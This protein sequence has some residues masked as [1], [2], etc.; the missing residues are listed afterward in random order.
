VRGVCPPATGTG[1]RAGACRPTSSACRIPTRGA[2]QHHCGQRPDPSLGSPACTRLLVGSLY[3]CACTM[4]CM[5]ASRG[6][7]SLDGASR[8]SLVLLPPSNNLGPPLDATGVPL[9]VCLSP[10]LLSPRGLSLEGVVPWGRGLWRLKGRVLLVRASRPGSGG[11]PGKC[12]DP[13][14]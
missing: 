3:A 6:C 7:G 10:D 13:K 8:T 14:V 9:G 11:Y 2:S 12:R 4:V 5:C 1:G